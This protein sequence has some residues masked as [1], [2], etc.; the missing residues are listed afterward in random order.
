[1]RHQFQ[2]KKQITRRK[3]I[4]RNIIGFGIFFILSVVGFLSWTGKIFNYVGKPI[5]SAEKFVTDGLYNTNYLFRSK[6]SI[7]KE[8][9]LLIEE[10]SD[11]K[12]S[13]IDYQILKN[14]VDKLKEILGRIPVNNDFILGNILAKPN[15]SLYDTLIIDIGSDL[16][17]KKGSQVYASGNIPIGNI[18]D[19]YDSTSLVSLYSSP[20]QKTE[21][22]IDITNIS[23]ELTGRGGGNFE[24]IIPIELII[25]K[26][27]MVLL[28]GNSSLV[29]A[30]V[31]EIISKPSD[32]FKK[33]ILTS[34]IN[35]QNIKWVQV[36]TN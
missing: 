20:G 35:V 10:I 33:V 22:F 6:A 27:T 21:G 25:N 1:M 26:G 36:K 3:K 29:V 11:K 19:V 23:V 13:M 14:D 34:P 2:D 5:W 9:H 31:D 30:V 28:P 16:K 15:H 7:T 32:P 12:L 17:L 4:I 18:A 24:M 8:N